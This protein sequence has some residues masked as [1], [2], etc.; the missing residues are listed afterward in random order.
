MTYLQ[1]NITFS[2]NAAIPFSLRSRTH[3][4]IKIKPMCI[5]SVCPFDHTFF[6]RLWE[7]LDPV[8]RFNHTSWVAVVIPTDRPMMFR[9]DI[10]W[11]FV[12]GGEGINFRLG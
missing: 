3:E 12:W 9:I 7:C 2:K 1:N 11:G 5:M 4:Y 6:L 8:S 10:L